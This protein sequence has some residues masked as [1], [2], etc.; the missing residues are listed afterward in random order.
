MRE[1]LGSMACIPGAELEGAGDLGGAVFPFLGLPHILLSFGELVFV[2]IQFRRGH[3]TRGAA[4]SG[5]HRVIFQFDEEL[6]VRSGFCFGHLLKQEGIDVAASGEEVEVGLRARFRRFNIGEVV[7]T[8][9]DPIVLIA[10]G[11]IEDVLVLG[12]DDEGGVA[13]LRLDAHDVPLAVGHGAARRR[14][15]LGNH[16]IRRSG[17]GGLGLF[18]RGNGLGD[19]SRHECGGQQGTHHNE[20]AFLRHD[21]SP[22]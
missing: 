12:Q 1:L 6:Q 22:G 11:K 14:D 5:Q 10:A 4:R 17:K 9:Y 8:V 7:R 19:R 20:T 18:D 2:G 16:R 21:S 13:K 15:L 3:K